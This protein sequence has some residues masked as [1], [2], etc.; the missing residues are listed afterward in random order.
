MKYI[1]NE[2]LYSVFFWRFSFFAD[3]C[4]TYIMKYPGRHF[5]TLLLPNINKGGQIDYFRSLSEVKTTTHAIIL[6]FIL[7]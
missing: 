3:K 5:Y 7:Y 6:S 2:V 4:N 1:T